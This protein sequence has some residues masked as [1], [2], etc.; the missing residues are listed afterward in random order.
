MSTTLQTYKVKNWVV[1]GRTTF[2]PPFNISDALINEARIVYVVNGRSNLY[3]A[4]QH[5]DLYPG[6]TLIMKPDNFVNHW[7]ENENDEFNEVIA[8]QLNADFLKYLYDNQIPQWFES[9]SSIQTN[10]VVKTGPH[11]L[12]KSFFD[13][14]K[15]YFAN[16]A[17]L[18]EEVIQL[19]IK[20]LISLLIQIDNQGAI[21]QIFGALFNASSYDFQEVI[22]KNLFENLNLEELAFLTGMSLSSFKRKFK[23][24]Y[25]TSP[26]KYFIS[27]RLE[28]AQNLIKTTDLRISDIA[29][30]CGFTDTSYFSKTFKNYYNISPSDLRNNA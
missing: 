10:A 1:F 29:Y 2:K 28:K 30:D 7:L 15:I 6:D 20:E 21:H 17:H 22:Q 11:P 5:I 19:K 23:S 13:N 25:G 3:S 24:I 4:N 14:L 26:T 18:S 16:P 12:L 27:K 9:E 8:F